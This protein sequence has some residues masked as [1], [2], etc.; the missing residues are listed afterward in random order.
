M[1]NRKNEAKM[2]VIWPLPYCADDIIWSLCDKHKAYRAGFMTITAASRQGA[3]KLLWLHFS[4]LV[5]PY[6]NK[7]ILTL[8]G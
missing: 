5:V 8:K 7:S 3:I 1:K 2:S 4:G 6:T